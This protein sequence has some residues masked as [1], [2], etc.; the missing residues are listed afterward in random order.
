MDTARIV[1]YVG[2]CRMSE[3]LYRPESYRIICAACWEQ[4]E[5]AKVLATE[6]SEMA[7][8]D[9]AGRSIRC[10]VCD[11]RITPS[12][13]LCGWCGLVDSDAEPCGCDRE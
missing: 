5:R 2:P 1:A 8:E 6:Y 7:A 13:T 3:A 11:E 10:R 12:E 9:F 4:E